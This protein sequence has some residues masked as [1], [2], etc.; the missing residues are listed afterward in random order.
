MTL[1]IIHRSIKHN[2]LAEHEKIKLKNCGTK[3]LKMP[4]TKLPSILLG[5]AN[6]VI[7]N[8]GFNNKLLVPKYLSIIFILN[9]L[10]MVIESP[11]PIIKAFTPKYLGKKIMDKIIKILPKI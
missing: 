5:I 8:N 7:K 10:D 4:P 9:I 3:Q 6:I 11:S 2:K 1:N